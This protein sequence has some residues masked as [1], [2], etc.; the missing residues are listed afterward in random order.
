MI[1]FTKTK[2]IDPEEKVKLVIV[3][4]NIRVIHNSFN[5]YRNNMRK[6]SK[7]H[8]VNLDTGELIEFKHNVNRSDRMPDFARSLSKLHDLILTNVCDITKCYFITV[9]YAEENVTPKKLNNDIDNLIKKIKRR[10]GHCEYINVVELQGRGVWHCHIILIFDEHVITPIDQ[11]DVE[12]CWGLGSAR[13]KP[14]VSA[15]GIARYLTNY[16]FGFD[17]DEIESDDRYKSKK[18]KKSERI[19]MYPTGFRLYRRSKGIKGPTVIKG[20]SHHA[21]KE[22]FSLDEPES[23]TGMLCINDVTGAKNFVTVE[24]YRTNKRKEKC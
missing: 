18:Q 12:M 14:I 15:E 24:K 1:K 2:A 9:T 8:G 19:S 22:K 5:N 17:A 10:Y 3:N 6:L 7:D 11:K 21:A 16:I 4:D 23:I 13:I 20:L